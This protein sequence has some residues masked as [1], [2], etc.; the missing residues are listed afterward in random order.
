MS[1]T[2]H[3]HGQHDDHDHSQTGTTERDASRQYTFISGGGNIN[4][5]MSSHLRRDIGQ[6]CSS[7]DN[8]QIQVYAT[9]CHEHV[10]I[11]RGYRRFH[12]HSSEPP[13]N[14][15]VHHWLAAA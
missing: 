3:N 13:R 8:V 5:S 11:K 1:S 7:V 4:L 14:H 10:Y 12:V 9:D 15:T 2:D 6:W